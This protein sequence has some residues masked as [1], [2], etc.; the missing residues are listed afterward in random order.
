MSSI[1]AATLTKVLDHLQKEGFHDDKADSHTENTAQ[2]VRLATED[3]IQNED[4]S[5]DDFEMI[6]KLSLVPNKCTQQSK[7]RLVKD[8]RINDKTKKAILKLITQGNTGCWGTGKMK[9][10]PRKK[11][12]QQLRELF[13]RLL[14]PSV[15]K[16]D[17]DEY[18][19]NELQDIKDVGIATL[20]TILYCLR[21]TEYATLNG[22]VR[23]GMEG[24][25]GRKIRMDTARYPEENDAIVVFRDENGLPKNLR[26]IDML[27][28]FDEFLELLPGNS[29]IEKLV[30]GF[31]EDYVRL[32]SANGH[33]QEEWNEAYKWR[34]LP[35][36]HEQAFGEPITAS[37]ILAKIEVIE[38]SNPPQGSFAHWME[39]QSLRMLAES[40]PDDAASLLENLRTIKIASIAEFI[41]SERERLKPLV[42][43]SQFGTPL[44]GYLLAAA[45]PDRFPLYK[46]DV[47]QKLR[48]ALGKQEE[49]KSMSIGEKYEQFR[50]NCLAIGKLL[51][52]K[53]VLETFT[54]DEIT[55]APG[56]T[57]LDGQDF[58]YMW[59]DKA[60]SDQSTGGKRYWLFAPGRD[61]AQWEEFYEKGIMG[62]DFGIREDLSK[63]SKNEEYLQLARDARGLEEDTNPTNNALALYE[64][65][66]EIQ[67]GDVIIVKQGRNAILGWGTVQSNYNYD[68]SRETHPHLRSVKWENRGE[69]TGPEPHN[70]K[71]LTDIT[72]YPKYLSSLL[73]LLGIRDHPPTSMEHLNLILYGPPGT[74]KTYSLMTEY[75]PKFTDNESTDIKDYLEKIVEKHPWWTV[76]AAVLL[77]KGP[78]GATI[79]HDHELMQAKIRASSNQNPKQAIW[80]N[81]Q[82]HTSPESILVRTSLERRSEP[83]LFDKKKGK[84]QE[85]LWHLF[86]DIADSDAP[87]IRELFKAYQTPPHN[88]TEKRYEFITFH[89]SYSY[90]EFIE[91]IRPE[92][93]ESGSIHYAVRDGIFKKIAQKAKDN[94]DKE[95]ALFIDEIN[96]GNI[97]KIF[98]ELITLLE[99]DKRLGATNELTVR[100]PYSND[101]FG[102]PKNLY[103]I[104][105]LNTAD[106]SIALIDLALRRR[107]EFR[108]LY[109]QYDLPG[110]QHSDLLQMLNERIIEE[111]GADYQI[112]HSYFL[113]K[114]GAFD[115]GEVM[116]RSILPLLNE[117]FYDDKETVKDILAKAGVQTNEVMGQLIFSSYA[118][119]EDAED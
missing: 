111:R 96:R 59:A 84:N 49:W 91:G 60:V 57:A 16:S 114:D 112:G 85:T 77:D 22:G 98:G 113:V 29:P 10:S 19:K 46:D 24:F 87:E 104:G 42:D 76:I 52:E 106:R 74:G 65:T 47:F 109:P 44:W 117:Y 8:S 45:D 61:A 40:H 55:V 17:I 6:R 67:K 7:E 70:V 83:F 94:P 31:I 116:N 88:Q 28:Y 3:L 115:L 27:F 58:L 39:L 15:S 38:K 20:S 103:V 5:V 63:Y 68:D 35:E 71:T 99:P 101:E 30:S 78:S 41:D 11:D 110:L 32:R 102:V 43:R 2:T 107:F 100:L 105:T 62:I 86:E 72:K 50:K 90:E 66:H 53:K 21:P 108:G 80:N 51:E 48:N 79:I 36:A 4:F 12:L 89:Q 9:M 82:D 73:A 25:F 97:S 23:D 56:L 1:P 33:E 69:W 92:T 119:P 64:F 34:I 75:F 37:N 13:K 93:D 81:L 54:A 26:S 95:Y 14:D 18:I 118:P